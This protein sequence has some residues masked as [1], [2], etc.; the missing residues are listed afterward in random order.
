LTSVDNRVEGMITT[1]KAESLEKRSELDEIE[2]LMQKLNSVKNRRER[3]RLLA[4]YN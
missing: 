4:E 2:E 1:E 3:K